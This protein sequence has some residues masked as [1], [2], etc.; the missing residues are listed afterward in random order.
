MSACVEVL[1][2]QLRWV[3][4]RAAKNLESGTPVRRVPAAVGALCAAAGG[5]DRLRGGRARSVRRA[6]TR[7]RPA[8]FKRAHL[9]QPLLIKRRLTCD[10]PEPCVGHPWCWHA[11]FIQ[12]SCV[13]HCRFYAS[14]CTNMPR[15]SKPWLAQWCTPVVARLEDT[16][17]CASYMLA[18]PEQPNPMVD[19][20]ALA[21][22]RCPCLECY[23]MSPI[24]TDVVEQWL[25][26]AD[27]W[28][29][30][31]PEQR[32]RAAGQGVRDACHPAARVCH[33]RLPAGHEPAAGA[34]LPMRSRSTWS[35][36]KRG[37]ER[38]CIALSS[39]SV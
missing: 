11:A 16:F 23:R 27:H 22:L 15:M 17:P 18:G 9:L 19:V 30:P 1:G 8:P 13:R 33:A 38:V 29:A 35:A 36:Q 21:S 2:S 12:L 25:Q 10:L 34:S 26:R 20:S 32:G 5:V 39:R 4:A 14:T 24:Q 37:V 31:A 3:F 7:T 28:S 6:G